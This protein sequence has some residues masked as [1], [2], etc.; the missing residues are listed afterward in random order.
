MCSSITLLRPAAELQICVFYTLI[1]LLANLMEKQ[2]VV[3]VTTTDSRLH[4]QVFSI[5][6]P[7]RSASHFF[8]R[9]QLCLFLLHQVYTSLRRLLFAGLLL[10]EEL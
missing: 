6:G 9:F 5:F 1:L 3:M 2:F 7:S 8:H 4:L 10:W